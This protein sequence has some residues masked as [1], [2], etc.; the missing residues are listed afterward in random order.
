MYLPFYKRSIVSSLGNVYFFTKF[1]FFLL[2]CRLV[3]GLRKVVLVELTRLIST[4]VVR[5][6]I[7]ML[8]YSGN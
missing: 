1:F 6:A 4:L 7:V 8:L 2:E 5:V 3:S